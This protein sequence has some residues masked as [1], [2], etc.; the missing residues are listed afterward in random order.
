MWPS[1]GYHD[2]NM[3]ST[4]PPG[5]SGYCDQGATYAGR[6]NQICG[7]G[8]VGPGKCE[9][10]GCWGETQ[11][12]VWRL[13]TAEDELAAADAWIKTDDHD[14]PSGTLMCDRLHSL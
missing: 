4:G 14:L 1:W 2:L 9:G 8:W 11:L 10:L 6:P 5:A 12:E 3:G 7:G 13:A